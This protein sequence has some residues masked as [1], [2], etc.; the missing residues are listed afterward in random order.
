MSVCQLSVIGTRR[1]SWRRF[2]IRRADLVVDGNV[3]TSTLGTVSY[4]N[5]NI[6]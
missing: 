6:G 2:N 4:V 3:T 1:S 5:L